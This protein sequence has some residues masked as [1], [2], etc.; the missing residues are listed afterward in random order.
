[1]ADL[2][3]VINSELRNLNCWILTNR[4]SFNIVNTEFKV[5][6]SNQRVH[7]LSNNQ[8]NIEIDGKS[9]KRVNKAKLLGLLINL[10]QSI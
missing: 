3:N 7:A 4:L 10:R 1:M 8:I 2:E 6:G 9:I 5:I